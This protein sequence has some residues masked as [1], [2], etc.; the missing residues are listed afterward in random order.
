MSFWGNSLHIII[1]HAIT[2]QKSCSITPIKAEW[3]TAMT[4]AFFFGKKKRKKSSL[5]P[6]M[7]G[8]AHLTLGKKRRKK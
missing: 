1:T 4:S 2:L 8:Q 6:S 3:T 7:E 5:P